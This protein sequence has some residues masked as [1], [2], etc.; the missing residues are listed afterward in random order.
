MELEKR[1]IKPKTDVRTQKLVEEI[2]ENGIP[3]SMAVFKQPVRSIDGTP[4]HAFYAPNVNG[5]NSKPYRTARLWLTSNGGILCFQTSKLIPAF[6]K[7][8]PSGSV[9]DTIIL[10]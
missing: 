5:P 4:E 6:Y 8:I 2:M 9:A 7:F 1:P 3:L 10:L